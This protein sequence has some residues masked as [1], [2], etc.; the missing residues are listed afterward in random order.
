RVRSIVGA[1]HVGLHRHMRSVMAADE[2]G[3]YAFRFRGSHRGPQHPRT[4]ETLPPR[5]ANECPPGW[6]SMQVTVSPR[7]RVQQ[8][9]QRRRGWKSILSTMPRSLPASCLPGFG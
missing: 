8:L 5:L 7:V 4:E 6:L 2:V 3:D 9:L 1:E